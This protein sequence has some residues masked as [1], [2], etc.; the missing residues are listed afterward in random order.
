MIDRVPG[1]FVSNTINLTVNEKK[2]IPLNFVSNRTDRLK[3]MYSLL[4]EQ[5][6]ISEGAYKYWKQH[7]VAIEESSGLY[8]TQPGLPISNL[9]CSDDCDKRV[10]GY[11]WVAERTER[12]IYVPRIN[13][14]VVYDFACPIYEYNPAIHKKM[15]RYIRVEEISVDNT[16][17]VLLTGHPGCFDCTMRGG[18]TTKPDFW[19]PG[20]RG[21]KLQQ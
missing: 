2:K 11:F 4:I 18:S 1:T 8:N 3:I 5:Y 19:D 21:I 13:N 15:P 7:N 17:E 10:L 16:G 9:Y 20:N 6:A 14:L 12:R